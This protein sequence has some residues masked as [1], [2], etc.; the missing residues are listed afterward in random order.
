MVSALQQG[1]DMIDFTGMIEI[2]SDHD[3]DDLARRQL[4]AS[5]RETLTVQLC[6]VGKIAN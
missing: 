1:A 6:I 5:I 4:V 3:L 2:M